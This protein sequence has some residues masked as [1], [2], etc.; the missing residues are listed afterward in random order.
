MNSSITKESAWCEVKVL[1]QNL[2]MG[3]SCEA[4][5]ER[6]GALGIWNT[7]LRLDHSTKQFLQSQRVSW[8]S[9]GHKGYAFHA[10]VNLDEPYSL[11]D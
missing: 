6:D 3:I 10:H 8:T 2:L 4:N 9:N 11:D 5:R 7:K 1:M